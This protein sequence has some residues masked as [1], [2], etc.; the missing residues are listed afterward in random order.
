MGISRLPGTT[1]E[2]DLQNPKR[3]LQIFE[4]LFS[5]GGLVLSQVA[6]LTG[7]PTYQVQNWV[8]RG[9]ISPPK[10]KRYTLR[11]FSR[12]AIINMLRDSMQIEK[13]IALIRYLNGRP[14]D[15]VDDSELYALF[16][17]LA[18]HTVTD[19]GYDGA[20]LER[21]LT[22]LETRYGSDALTRLRH[23]LRIMITAHASARLRHQVERQMIEIN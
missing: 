16:V 7:M 6:S 3:A 17:E 10:Q 14:G 15:E 2:A 12:I 23:V 5:A 4:P 21:E 20:A 8:K 13:I 9:F 22:E 19:D 18:A 1:I 11:Q